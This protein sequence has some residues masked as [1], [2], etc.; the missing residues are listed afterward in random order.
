MDRF[1]EGVTATVTFAGG[2][3]TLAP[4][5]FR[6]TI[7]YNNTDP[8]RFFRNLTSYEVSKLFEISKNSLTS[9]GSRFSKIGSS[10]SKI[11][12]NSESASWNT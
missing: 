10:I 5:I 12:W 2:A 4:D 7:A 3:A 9:L 1:V 11:A 6:P 8:Y